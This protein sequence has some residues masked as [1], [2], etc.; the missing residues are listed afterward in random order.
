MDKTNNEKAIHAVLD[1]IQSLKK[2]FNGRV[3]VAAHHYQQA[4]IVQLADVVGDSYKLAVIASQSKAEIIILCGVRFMA[5]SAAI[6]ARS[7]QRILL[8]DFSAGCP[9]ADMASRLVAEKTLEA[10]HTL[11]GKIPVPITYMN[12]W[13]DLKALTGAKGGSICTS[14]NAQKI[15][16]YFLKRGH[17]ILFMP[18]KNLGYN[19]ARSLGLDEQEIAYVS[20]DGTLVSN[21]REA[22]LFLWEGYCPIHLKFTPDHVS[23]LRSA[24][25]ESK[26]IVHPECTEDVVSLS[27]ASSSTEGMAKTIAASPAG[28]VLGVGTEYSFIERMMSENPN[29][30]I[31]PLEKFYCDDM[32][33]IT[34]EKLLRVLKALRD[35]KEKEFE[36]LISERDALD[37]RKALSTMVAITEEL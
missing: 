32:S 24:H 8:P 29:K 4:H 30:K 10:I 35:G 6:L 27:D 1:E 19:T 3:L 26:L 25:P 33:L 36:I 31:I 21:N 15:L 20:Q 37:A 9:M 22:R 16:S 14:G 28:S 34:P 13:V 11:T 17:N 7:D 23:L 5:E 12:S 2:F 18:D